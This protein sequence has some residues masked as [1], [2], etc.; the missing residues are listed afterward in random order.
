MINNIRLYYILIMETKTKKGGGF[1]SMGLASAVY[2]AIK[3][4]G[5][6]VPTPIQRKV[7]PLILGG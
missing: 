4:K 7:I 2:Q 5:Y 3:K 1:E 6:N